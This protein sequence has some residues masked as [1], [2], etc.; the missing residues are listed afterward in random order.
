MEV[1]MEAITR[2]FGRRARIIAD[3]SATTYTSVQALAEAQQ[4]NFF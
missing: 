1:E 3:E 4:C 2:Q